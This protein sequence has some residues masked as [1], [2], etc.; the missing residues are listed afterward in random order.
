MICLLKVLSSASLVLA[1]SKFEYDNCS[2][3]ELTLVVSNFGSME[4]QAW[5]HHCSAPYTG[6]SVQQSKLTLA[7]NIHKHRA[8]GHYELSRAHLSYKP[9]LQFLIAISLNKLGCLFMWIISVILCHNSKLYYSHYSCT[10]LL[11]QTPARK[12]V[13]ECLENTWKV[14]KM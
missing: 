3:V 14:M 2:C 4:L 12:D 8:D 6:N 9:C 13:S 10:V 7:L 11:Q 5:C 1:H